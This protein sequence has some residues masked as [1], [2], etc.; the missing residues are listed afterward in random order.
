M[1]EALGI[2]MGARMPKNMWQGSRRPF[3]AHIYSVK[4]GGLVVVIG[5]RW[6]QYRFDDRRRRTLLPLVG[7]NDTFQQSHLRLES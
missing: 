5:G 7:P 1:V 6:R 4:G 3:R 2:Q